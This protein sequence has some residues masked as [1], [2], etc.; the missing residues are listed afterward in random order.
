MEDIGRLG[1]SEGWGQNLVAVTLEIKWCSQKVQEVDWRFR[2]TV[3]SLHKQSAFSG[4]P[5]I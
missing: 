4:P 1:L 2:S 3:A 5:S